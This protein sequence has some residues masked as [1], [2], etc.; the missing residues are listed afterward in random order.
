MGVDRRFL[1]IHVSPAAVQSEG[2]QQVLDRIQAAGAV[3]IGTG[4]TV[5]QPAAPGEGRRE[6]PIDI[7]G[8]SRI[9]DRP[10][11]GKRET[12]LRGYRSY[13]SGESLYA[14]TRYRP[15]GGLGQGGDLAPGGDHA[16]AGLDCDLPHRILE[17]AHRRGMRAYLALSPLSVPGLRPEDQPRYVDGSLPDPALRVAGQGCPNQPDVRAYAVVLVRDAVRAFPEADGIYLDWLEYTV[18]RLE[19]H[20]ACFCPH[21]ARRAEEAGYAWGRMTEDAR[22]LW[23]RLH[24]LGPEDLARAERLGRAPWELARLL[25]DYPG[26]ADLWRFKADTVVGACEEI[27]HAMDAE[28]AAAMEL[29]ANGWAPPWSLSSGM[30]YGRL[31]RACASVR[32]KLYT[33]HWSTLPRWY[34]ETLTAWNPGLPEGPLLDALVSVMGVPDDLAPRTFDRYHIPAPDEP[35]PARPEAWG[36]KIGQVVDEVAGRTRCYAYAHA[37][38]PAAQW[39]EMVR[40]VRESRADGM[41]VQRY[42]YM[43]DEKLDILAK[44][45]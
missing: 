10:L 8:T 27:R 1:G 9:L 42:G 40:T 24:A 26:W 12:W 3:A 25:R 22:A 29:G 16:P 38:R 23:D 15:G 6:P 2:L 4:T 35:H 33:F 45:W 13:A 36:E 28:G 37:Y 17:E 41:W 14:D 7:D 19:D 18:Y 30:A 11:W 31:G 32:P 34:G 39:R 44:E 5:F 20:F 21:C 43:S